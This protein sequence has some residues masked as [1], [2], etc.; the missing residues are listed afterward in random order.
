[1]IGPLVTP[2]Y[3]LVAYIENLLKSYL[4][5]SAVISLPKSLTNTFRSSLG[6]TL[7]FIENATID[8]L[9]LRVITTFLFF[10]A[11]AGCTVNEVQEPPAARSPVSPRRIC[12][13][14]RHRCWPAMRT[15]S[16]HRACRALYP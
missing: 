6:L 11:R 10:L 5:V 14:C 13:Q 4:S 16:P 12:E 7:L 9:Q 2:R 15:S 1:M 8:P 3:L